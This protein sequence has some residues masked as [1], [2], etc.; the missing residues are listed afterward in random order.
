MTI[1]A[2]AFIPLLMV[3]RNSKKTVTSVSNYEGKARKG[4]F[5][6]Q[7]LISDLA[8]HQSPSLE[9]KENTMQNYA[10][11]CRF[12]ICPCLL[13]SYSH[14]SWAKVL[15]GVLHSMQMIESGFAAKIPSTDRSAR[16][17]Q[18]LAANGIVS[19]PLQHVKT[20]PPFYHSLQ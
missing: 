3:L 5:Y 10:K 11:V 20:P 1:S 7:L 15:W 18:A 13:H 17:F 8:I 6:Q 19:Q 12:H 14:H 2:E 9:A 16:V 4:T